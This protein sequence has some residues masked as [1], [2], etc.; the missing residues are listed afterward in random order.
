MGF[1]MSDW[2]RKLLAYG[3]LFEERVMDLSVN[4]HLFDAL[5]RCWEILAECFEPA[6][7]GIRRSII[8]KHWPKKDGHAE[9]KPEPV[10][11]ET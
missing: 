5:D 4:I 1:E 6:E 2:D 9:R 8:D 3:V 7:T 10:G 11:A